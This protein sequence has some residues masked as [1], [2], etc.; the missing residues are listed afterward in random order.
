MDFRAKIEQGKQVGVT[1]SVKKEGQVLWSSVAIQKWE[2]V[3]KVYIDEVFESKMDI[4]EY[5]KDILRE[6]T[7]LDTALSFIRQN[8]S[9]EINSLATLKGQRIFNPKFKATDTDS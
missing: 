8:S 6:F 9:A 1:F 7:S 3:Y 2:G 4:E 5:E